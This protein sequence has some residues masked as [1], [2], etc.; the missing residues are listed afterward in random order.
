MDTNQIPYR[1]ISVHGKLLD[2]STPRVMGILNV[3]PDSF[4]CNSRM[5]SEK[6][7]AARIDEVFEQGASIIDLGAYSSRPGAADVSEEEEIAR[8]RPALKEIRRKYPEALVSIDTFRSHVAEVCVQEYGADI[9][10]DISAGTLDEQMFDTMARLQV[11][12]IIMHMQGTPRTMQQKPH[13]TDLLREIIL[14]MEE[15]LRMLD[16]LGVK[17]VIVD[18]GFGF[19]KTL[20][21]NYE[22]LAGLKEFSIL[23]RPMLV[24]VSRKS[25][26]YNLLETTPEQALNGTTAVQTIALMQGADILRVHD[27]R[28]A[29]ETIRIFSRLPYIP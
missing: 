9:I 17:D 8:L 22:L 2:L 19:G 4:Y 7:I 14:Y 6:A 16:A 12:Y 18:P 25:M 21:H 28:Q 13:Y 15:R 1:T 5:Q 3:T 10:N 24:G 23:Q 27:V 20:E 29:M 26:I 11:P